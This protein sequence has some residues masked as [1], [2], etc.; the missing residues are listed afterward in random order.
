MIARRGG[1]AADVTLQIRRNSPAFSFQ[2]WRALDGALFLCDV[3]E[4]IRPAEQEDGRDPLGDL[5]S[6]DLSAVFDQPVIRLRNPGF[7]CNLVGRK[8]EPGPLRL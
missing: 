3:A 5:N 6:R 8:A 4:E 1:D 2:G 7:F